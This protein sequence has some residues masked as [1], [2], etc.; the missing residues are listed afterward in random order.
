MTS[1]AGRGGDTTTCATVAPRET[2]LET[3]TPVH[4][5]VRPE[6]RVAWDPSV[7]D[8]EHLGRKSSKCL[9]LSLSTRLHLIFC[10]RTLCLRFFFVKTVCCIFHKRHVFG[11]DSGSSSSSSSDSSSSS[12]SSSCSSSEDEGECADGTHHHCC[13][14]GRKHRKHKRR[15]NAYERQPRYVQALQEQL[16]R[17]KEL[18]QQQQQRQ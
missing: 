13:E 10:S 5:V 16:K 8:N 1:T 15:M 4:I 2:E 12:S 3:Q 11:E 17:E 7:V 14:D 9:S 18:Q 6:R